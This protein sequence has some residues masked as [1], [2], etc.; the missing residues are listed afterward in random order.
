M[1]AVL[2]ALAAVAAPCRGASQDSEEPASSHRQRELIARIEEEQT[3]HGVSGAQLI[4]P[5]TELALFYREHGDRAL[6]KAAAERANGIVRMNLGLK[7]LEQGP[8]LRLLSQIEEAQG[9]VERAWQLELELF[10]LVQDH[11]GDLGTVP[12]LHDL[13]ARRTALLER[14]SG[15]E[16]PPQIMLGC[17]YSHGPLAAG[18]AQPLPSRAGPSCHSGSRSRVLSTL[19]SEVNAYKFMA[20]RTILGSDLYARGQLDELTDLAVDNCRRYRSDPHAACSE[21][22]ALVK[23]LAYE[24]GSSVREVDALVRTADWRM[25]GG[26]WWRSRAQQAAGLSF[27]DCASCAAARD[28]YRRAYALLERAGVAQEAIDRVFAP[29]V[30]VLLPGMLKNPY[31]GLGAETPGRHV[32]VAFAVTQAGRA[33][34]VEVRDATPD[35][36]RVEKLH[37]VQRIERSRFRP[38][39]VNGEVADA[40]PV[41]VRYDLGD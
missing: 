8:L 30:P 10:E 19:A 23:Q 40:A 26:Q 21:E 5:L 29:R 22:I 2:L 33:V 16:I 15:G 37:L 4:E 39:I 28:A 18:G 34:N 11:P 13:S 6:A 38:M 14:Y 24:V 36:S 20:V 31:V 3:L 17:Y 12:I 1:A 32:V 9:D 35:V 27:V 25:V 7:T 41:V